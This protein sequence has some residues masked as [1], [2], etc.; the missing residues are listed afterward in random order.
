MAY[1][2]KNFPKGGNIKNEWDAREAKTDTLGKD[3]E[4]K[5]VSIVDRGES[6][7]WT[8]IKYSNGYAQAS[9]RQPF[10]GNVSSPWGGLFYT[11]GVTIDH[12]DIFVGK[13]PV[14]IANFKLKGGHG[15][16]TSSENFGKRYC[17]SPVAL[18]N[19]TGYIDVN[20]SGRWKL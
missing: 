19:V 5:I 6:L 8:W 18:T 12:P 4:S 13:E 3:S 14:M 7:N 20:M 11:A 15:I 9:G 1:T 2:I 10:S 17:I 16:W